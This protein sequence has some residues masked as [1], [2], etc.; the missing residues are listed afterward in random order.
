MIGLEAGARYVPANYLTLLPKLFARLL[1]RSR[2]KG[3]E[4]LY[5]IPVGGT[6]PL[7]CLG[8]VSAAMELK[9]QI[10]A[11]VLPEPDFLYVA[12]GSLGTAAGLTLGCRLARMA[13]KG[14]RERRR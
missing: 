3:S 8:H 5:C 12:A 13:R 14:R 4:R 9:Q 6:S 1:W 2:R 10:A 7:A 11:G